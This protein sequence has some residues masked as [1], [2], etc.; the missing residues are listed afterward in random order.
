MP[1]VQG[2][3]LRDAGV[4]VPPTVLGAWLVG[5]A[6]TA[7]ADRSWSSLQ[8]KDRRAIAL[9]ELAVTVLT[10]SRSFVKMVSDDSAHRSS[11]R[12]CSLR[13]AGNHTQA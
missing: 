10:P 8:D 12:S 5:Q 1:A 11:S 3:T 9:Q 4:V 13:A 6:R 2:A 7:V